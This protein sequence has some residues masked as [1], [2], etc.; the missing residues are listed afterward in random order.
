VRGLALAFLA[1]CGGGGSSVGTDAT[2]QGPD[3]A[4][5]AHN[6]GAEL[7]VY[8]SSVTT[9][10]TAFAEFNMQPAQC[11]TSHRTGSCYV[12]TC[13]TGLT[14]VSAGTVTITGGSAPIT[15]TPDGTGSYSPFTTMT[16]VAHPGDPLTVTAA[17][18]V[19]PAYTTT[20]TMPGPL[21]ITSPARPSTTVNINRGADFAVQWS[22]GT[23]GL[24]LVTASAASNPN[25]FIECEVQ[26]SAGTATLP[27][28]LLSMLAAGQGGIG[29][30]A[31][32][33]TTKDAGT[34]ALYFSLFYDSL[35]PDGTPA[36]IAVTWN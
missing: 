32:A 1:A 13:T 25:T 34:W 22:G 4:P 18:E 33:S 26:A 30:T 6:G 28:T 12:Q 27:S 15:L 17:G 29:I 8:K 16:D 14:A 19:A 2:G 5:P 35:W 31:W 21:T 3:A 36:S 20:L 7:T 9:G 24:A 10:S 11:T 23:S